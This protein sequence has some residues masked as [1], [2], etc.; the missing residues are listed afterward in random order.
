MINVAV[1]GMG[2]MG[3]THALAWKRV[4]GARVAA[5]VTRDPKKAAGD[6]RGV[7]GN[8][9]SSGGRQ[10]LTGIAR[11]TELAQALADDRIDLVDICLPTWLH[12][13]ATLASL[14][15]GR[16]VLLEKPIG[17]NVRDADQMIRAARAARC[18]FMVAHVLRYFPEYRLIKQLQEENRHG[19]IQA[20]HFKRCIARPAWWSP[21]DLVQNGGP[22][23]DLHIH[24]SDFVRFLFG[25]PSAV[26]AQ[27]VV[28]RGRTV[29]YIQTQYRFGRRKI[30]ISAEGGWLS[31]AGCPFEHGYDVYFERAALKFNSSWGKPPQLLTADGK[32]TQPKL[33]AADA[34]LGELQEAADA[35]RGKRDSAVLSA[36]SARESLALCLAEVRSVH[37]GGKIAV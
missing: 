30:A 31:Q 20:A 5:I 27:G 21:G 37:S 18:S 2:F 9:G 19:A 11:Y 35:L 36:R 8:F 26:L 1:V 7:Q 28:G 3:V 6:W 16:N 29:E 17:L 23:V 14:A 34:F 24:D 13:D 33:P 22:A 4:K 12:K 32:V 15:A 25:E 10:N